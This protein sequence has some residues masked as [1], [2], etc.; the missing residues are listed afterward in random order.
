MKGSRRTGRAVRAGSSVAVREASF[1]SVPGAG[2]LPP[3]LDDSEGARVG[4]TGGVTLDAVVLAG[5]GVAASGAV[6]SRVVRAG[7]GATAREGPAVGSFAPESEAVGSMTGAAFG[8]G[9]AASGAAS[10]FVSR[11]GGAR[12]SG[13]EGGFTVGV[14]VDTGAEGGTSRS[15]RRGAGAAGATGRAGAS[16]SLGCVRVWGARTRESSRSRVAVG[17]AIT[18]LS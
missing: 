12:Y 11:A 9:F 8:A 3:A 4:A 5:G 18:A 1:A 2:A 17:S 13:A 16:S 14:G 6:S 7:G 15:L 10:S